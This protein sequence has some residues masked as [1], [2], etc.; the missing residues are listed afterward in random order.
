MRAF[1]RD[2]ADGQDDGKEDA[3]IAGAWVAWPIQSR[4]NTKEKKHDFRNAASRFRGGYRN[5]R[6]R[7]GGD[8]LGS[9]DGWKGWEVMPSFDHGDILALHGNAG[10]ISPKVPG[11]NAQP[12]QPSIGTD[13]WRISK[14][15]KRVR[16]SQ[17]RDAKPCAG[18]GTP[19]LVTGKRNSSAPSDKSGGKAMRASKKR[20]RTIGRTYSPYGAITLSSGHAL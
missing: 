20:S 2:S 6:A 11:L 14:T 16:N 13:H 12:L 10:R 15:A 4:A 7:I 9:L 19:E 1:S 17:I 18:R 8:A 3:R 5:G